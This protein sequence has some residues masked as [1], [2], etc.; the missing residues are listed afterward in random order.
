MKVAVIGVGAMGNAMLGHMV[1]KGIGEVSAYDVDGG[2][3]AAATKLGARAAPSAAAA[4]AEADLAILMVVNDRQVEE[5]VDELAKSVPNPLLVAV[6]ATI[7]PDT[8]VAAGK[9]LAATSIRLI[10][11]PVV[12][13][14]QGAIE[15]NMVT[16][17]GGAADDVAAARPALL[18]Y[19]RAVHHVGP[20]GAGMVA[21]TANNM[22]HWAN[23]CAGFETLLLVKRYGLDAQRMREILLDC[24]ARSG[25]LERWDT[26][27]FTWPEKD[28][29]IALEMA[30]SLGLSLPL[31]GMVDQLI[32]HLSADGVRDLLYGP[33]VNYLGRKVE[34]APPGKARPAS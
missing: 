31:F 34:P 27:H 1:R 29:D 32:K 22:L 3:L 14:L 4:A 30:Q 7:H 24:P 33:S 12:Y 13:G 16:L 26:T 19:S 25:T 23:S 15:G 11:A 5:I 18:A 28:M 20:L 9:R 21:K 17:C 6:A 8:M 2:R 10:D